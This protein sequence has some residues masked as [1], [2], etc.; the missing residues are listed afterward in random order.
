MER[1]SAASGLEANCDKSALYVA[2]MDSEC[3]SMLCELLNMPLGQM[4]F[5]YLG[6]LLSHRKLAYAECLPLLEKLSAVIR[7]WSNKFLSYA[8]RIV[9]IQSV[10]EGIKGFWSQIFLLPKKVIR[11]LEAICRKFLWSG[12]NEGRRAPIAWSTVCSPKCIGGFRIKDFISWNKVG[13]LKQ[14]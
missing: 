11:E 5:R 10:V 6:V 2:G 8:A 4:L 3:S 12:S 13:V 14:L 1:F 9:L 7:Q